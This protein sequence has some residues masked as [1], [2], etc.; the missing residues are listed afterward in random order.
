MSLYKIF[1]FPDLG[2]LIVRKAA[3]HVLRRRKYFGG[4]TVDM[5]VSLEEQWHAKKSDS[6]HDQ[7]E[8]G[9]LPIH[10]IMAVRPALD[11]H[12]ELFGTL[13]RVSRH[14]ARLAQ[15]LYDGLSSLRHSNNAAVCELYK[16][17]R[18]TYG[19]LN[20]Q[21]PIVAFN[22]R[23]GEGAWISNP[24]VEKLA[25]VKNIQLRTGGLC[26]PGGIASSLH[27][28]PWEMRQNFSTG[29]RCGSEND[30]MN[31]KPTGMVRVSLGAMS[32]TR[33]VAAFMKFMRDFFVQS[34][35]VP[36]FAADLPVLPA[37]QQAF[38]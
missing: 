38:H 35:V 34:E 18:S 7:L 22:I 10:S 33:D 6:L 36:S 26:N 32:T 17:S 29:Q 37:H 25:A 4:G 8:D 3:G 2:A 21:G 27:L 9:T 28:A 1:G 31:G 16:D 14:T 5:V 24:E 20:T 23:N 12:Q 13:D 11:V 19:D 30:V 15:D